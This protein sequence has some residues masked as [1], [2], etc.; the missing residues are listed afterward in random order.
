MVQWTPNNNV[1]VTKQGIEWAP[2]VIQP[3][4]KEGRDQVLHQHRLGWHSHFPQ[5]RLTRPQVSKKAIAAVAAP[6]G[7]YE[8]G[9]PF[10]LDMNL[11]F[12][13]DGTMDFDNN[14]KTAVRQQIVPDT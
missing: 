9:V 2:V 12:N 5:R 4:T 3:L 13:S 6:T 11:N 7:H 10:I 1:K 14:V 8:G